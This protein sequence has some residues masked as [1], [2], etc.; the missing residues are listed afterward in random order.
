MIPD[1][2]GLERVWK[3]VTQQYTV[4]T[5]PAGAEVSWKAYGEL[6]GEWEVAGRTPLEDARFPFSYLRWAGLEGRLRLHGTDR[7]SHWRGRL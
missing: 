5:E 6:D 7:V 3:S 4:R 1:D 2:P